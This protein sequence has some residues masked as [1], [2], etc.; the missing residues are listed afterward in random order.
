MYLNFIYAWCLPRVDPEELDQ[1]ITDL[2]DLLPWQD[3]T[4]EA[5]ANIESQSFM[6][7]MSK[8]S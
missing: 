1:W 8:Q 6:N 2:D 3:S 5:A 4:T 7:M